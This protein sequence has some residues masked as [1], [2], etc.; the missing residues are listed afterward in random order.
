MSKKMEPG[1]GEIIEP[2]FEEGKPDEPDKWRSKLTDR[3][4]RMR[5]LETGERYGYG[6]GF[7][8]ERRKSKA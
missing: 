8:S 4:R 1:P 6:E 3:K 7:V 5:Y 2:E